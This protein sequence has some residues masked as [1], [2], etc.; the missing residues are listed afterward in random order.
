MAWN[1]GSGPSEQLN[2]SS[3]FVKYKEFIGQASGHQ[4]LKK[5]SPA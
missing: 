3:S 1:L 2:E 4:L 5:D